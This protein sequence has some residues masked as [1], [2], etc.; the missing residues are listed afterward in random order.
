MYGF[1]NTV[2][3]ADSATV[4]GFETLESYLDLQE[5]VELLQA[6]GVNNEKLRGVVAASALRRAGLE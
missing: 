2:E 4:D 3:L 1:T 5:A 6:L